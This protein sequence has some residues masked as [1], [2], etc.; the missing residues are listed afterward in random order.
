MSDGKRV[1][2]CLKYGCFGC[3]ALGGTAVLVVGVLLA[4]AVLQS[5][6]DEQREQRELSQPLPP[7]TTEGSMTGTRV[8]AGGDA[9]PAP[10]AMPTP[11]P[12]R[13][14]LNLRGG[15]VRILPG[16]PGEPIRVE[17]NFDT[18]RFE[19]R[20][21]FEAQ[22]EGS[23]GWIYRLSFRPLGLG[24]LFQIHRGD[25]PE[26]RLYLPPGAP[27]A[28]EGY[29]G[30][31][32]SETEI[33]GLWI[34]DADLRMGMGEHTLSVGK[35][36][37]VPMGRF[38]IDSS[39]GEL[40]ILSLGNASPSQ[41]RVAHSMGA[42][43]LDLRGAWTRDAQ[44]EARCRMGGCRVRAPRGVKFENQNTRIV[45]GEQRVIGAAELPAPPPGAPT[46]RLH[47]SA[48]MGELRVD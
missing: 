37:A 16:K 19:L 45:F 11:A 34:T 35:P 39:M 4:V 21:K 25:E 48:S 36:L 26:L 24:R 14:V 28:L 17:A 23:Q 3:L 22:V 46:V 15:R 30:M 7:A 44:V 27:M 32:Q 10:A 1:K 5:S 18:K 8:E 47:V 9:G 31:G 41:V 40:R 6:G 33:G 12:G 20:E 43:L 42:M 2:G 38:T 29:V 13:V